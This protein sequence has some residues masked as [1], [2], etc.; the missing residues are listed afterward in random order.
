E[1]ARGV[2][3]DPRADQGRV[4]RAQALVLAGLG[5]G[6]SHR[7]ERRRATPDREAVVPDLV[8]AG[9]GMA[10]LAAA[11]EARS[12]GADVL[13]L[14]KGDVAGGAMRW[15]SGVI[16]RHRSFADFRA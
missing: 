8:V 5:R 11:A 2:P 3:L 12:R 13:L 1:H 6:S 9:A 7:R 15:S 4:R 14:E 16:W 10:G